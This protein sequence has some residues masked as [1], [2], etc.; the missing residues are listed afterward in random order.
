MKTTVCD[1]CGKVVHADSMFR[2]SEVGS[3]GNPDH[4]FGFQSIG[5]GTTEAQHYYRMRDFCNSVCFIQD[6]V[7]YIGVPVNLV[8]LDSE[9]KDD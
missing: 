2:I 1:F 3:G 9:S 8:V 6:L 5:L 7:D 4:V